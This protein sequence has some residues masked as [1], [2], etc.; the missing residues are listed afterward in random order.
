MNKVALLE[1]RRDLNGIIAQVRKGQRL[2]L[3]CRGKPVARLE[4]I[5]DEI[6]DANDPF[7]SLPELAESG[8]SLSNAQIDA[9]VYGK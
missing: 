7:Y 3:T 5:I 9:I 2:I 1:I 8:Q 4:P 6:P